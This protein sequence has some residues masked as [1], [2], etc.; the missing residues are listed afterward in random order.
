M[1]LGPKASEAEGLQWEWVAGKVQVSGVGTM[2]FGVGWCGPS[3]VGDGRRGCQST[4]CGEASCGGGDLSSWDD[5]EML[6]D[7]DAQL[8]F[9]FVVFTQWSDPSGGALPIHRAP[10]VATCD[11]HLP[12]D[13]CH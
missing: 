10:N 5:V 12:T 9:P 4:L 7:S 2:G 13:C 8:G 1:E 3:G 11:F 6:R